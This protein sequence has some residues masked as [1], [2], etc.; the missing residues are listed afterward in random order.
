MR[1]FCNFHSNTCHPETG[2]CFNC[3]DNTVGDSCEEC[4]TGYYRPTSLT[5]DGCVACDCYP[6]GTVGRVCNIVSWPCC[7]AN[8]K[9]FTLSYRTKYVSIS[10]SLTSSRKIVKFLC[11]N[12]QIFLVALDKM[13]VVYFCPVGQNVQCCFLR[14]S[15]ILYS[16][17]LSYRTKHSNVFTFVL[18]DSGQCECTEGYTGVRCDQ[19]ADGYWNPGNW[20]CISELE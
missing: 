10:R 15:S 8:L 20:S 4:K 11:R 2:V 19:C 18:Q 7:S 3:T 1:C 17:L 16:S 5:I 14:F 6:P 9:K 13:A 12:C